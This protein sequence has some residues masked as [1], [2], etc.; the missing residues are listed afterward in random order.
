ME[1]RT[2]ILLGRS[3]KRRDARDK[4]RE[5]YARAKKMPQG[6]GYVALEEALTEARATGADAGVGLSFPGVRLVTTRC[7]HS[8]PGIQRRY[9]LSSTGVLTAK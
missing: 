9:R 2:R 6:R 3:V 7:A 4:V 1:K 5:A 8:R